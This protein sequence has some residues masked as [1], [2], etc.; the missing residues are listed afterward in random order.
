VPFVNHTPRLKAREQ[1]GY[2]YPLK[3]ELIYASCNKLLDHFF[4]P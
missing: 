3:F 4:R 1:W 2:K